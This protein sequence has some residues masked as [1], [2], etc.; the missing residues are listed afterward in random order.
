MVFPRANE[1]K[2]R[3]NAKN[4]AHGEAVGANSVRPHQR[5]KHPAHGEASKE[6][7]P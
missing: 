7:K 1:I 2:T 6:R 5:D 4:P 3:I